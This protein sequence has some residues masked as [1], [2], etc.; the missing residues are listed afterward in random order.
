MYYFY[1]K[2]IRKKQN[3]KK[4]RKESK[5]HYVLFITRLYNIVTK[6]CVIA[7]TINYIS[8]Y[9]SILFMFGCGNFQIVF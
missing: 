8:K 6:K 2:V 7:F 4:V 3:Q 9:I 1:C 5:Y